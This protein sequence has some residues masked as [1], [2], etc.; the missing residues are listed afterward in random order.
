MCVTFPD[1]SSG[2][3]SCGQLP[4]VHLADAASR[5]FV[6][7]VHLT[8]CRGGVEN[9]L[10]VNA[11]LGQRRRRVTVEPPQRPRP[12]ADPAARRAHQKP[13]S[14]AP[15]DAR[16]TRPRPAAGSTVSPPVLIASSIRPSTR[17]T[18]ELS[19][20]PTSSV[21]KPARLREGILVRRRI[22]VALGDGGAAEGDPT[23][24]VDAHADTRRAERRRIRSRRRSRSCRRS[25]PP[26]SPRPQPFRRYRRASARRRSAPRPAR[27]S[28]A[29]A[30][31][32]A[33]ALSSCAATS[34][35]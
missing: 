27:P 10:D 35:A 29:A 2:A 16:P 13:R 28:A 23:V 3:E 32:S 34:E 7:E 8:R 22:A 30:A 12:R 19:K 31:G 4:A 15:A 5:Q 24:V 17:S 20:A 9:R 1:A 25:A 11:Q 14:R 6:D 21:M 18:P 26:K 33:S